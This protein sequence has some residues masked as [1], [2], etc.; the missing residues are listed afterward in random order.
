MLNNEIELKGSYSFSKITYKILRKITN[1]TLEDRNNKFDEWFNYLYK[2]TKEEEQFLQ[3]LINKEQ[4]YFKYFNE[5]M[6][7]ASFIIP[8]LSK[9]DF[10]QE[11]F[12]DWYEYSISGIVNGYEL[13]G[14]IDFMLASGTI[15]PETPYFFIQEFKKSKTNSDPDFQ[16]LAEMAV[17]ME[18]NKTN[19]IK[20]VYNIGRFWYFII[21]EKINIDKYQYFESDVFDCLKIK[22]LKQIYI[23]LQAVKLKYCK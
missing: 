16:L 12:R 20:G 7:K 11:N 22:D 1:I 13:S 19:S 2:I 8:L 15:E 9:I 4:K 21:L 18:I 3:K 17:A 6:Q 14:N 10:V 5:E 23:N